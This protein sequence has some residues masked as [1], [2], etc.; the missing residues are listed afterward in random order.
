LNLHNQESIPQGSFKPLEYFGGPIQQAIM[1]IFTVAKG[2]IIPLG[3][4]FLINND[5]LMMTAKHVL[6]EVVTGRIRKRGTS[7]WMNIEGVFA[8]FIT[9]R[10]LDEDDMRNIG[11]PMAIIKCW[12]SSELDIAYCFLQ[13]FSINEIPFKFQHVLR[14]SPRV[15]S[16][17]EQI[18]GFGY[19][20]SI[21]SEVIKNNDKSSAEYKHKTAFASG[22]I[23]SVY[24]ERRDSS[25]LNFP[26]F[27]TTARFE[28][29]MSG[30]PVFS[31]KGGVCGVIVSSFSDD[32]VD[33]VSFASLI[34]PALGTS[35]EANINGSPEYF[36]VYD[37]CV[38]GIVAVDDTLSDVQIFRFDD[39][40]R[41][42][43]V[44]TVIGWKSE[45]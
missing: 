17:G 4:G 30:G 7:D 35:I 44:K 14:L 41:Q 10:V 13:T 22:Q 31:E 37:L 40:S 16:A 12:F 3:T 9:D 1:P 39:D 43:S 18:L 34:W 2:E 29:G 25:M 6:E 8:M 26:C 28:P 15:P 42:V 24:I 38:K 20:S 19:H 21:G 27:Q 5:G 33:Y 45:I 23:V 32:Q 11:G 36:M